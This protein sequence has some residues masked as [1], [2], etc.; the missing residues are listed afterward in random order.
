[1]IGYCL[2]RRYKPGSFLLLWLESITQ[3]RHSITDV[4]SIN[5]SS[6]FKIGRLNSS[7]STDYTFNAFLEM[8]SEPSC[9]VFSGAE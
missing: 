1:M 4:C 3:D 2:L 7:L 8:S 5:G 9:F 6:A